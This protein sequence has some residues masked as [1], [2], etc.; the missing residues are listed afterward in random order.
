MGITRAFAEGK[1]NIDKNMISLFDTVE[2]IVGKGENTDHLHFLLFH[3]GFKN[4]V[5]VSLKPWILK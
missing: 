4:S 2:N 3:Q 1:F 5:S